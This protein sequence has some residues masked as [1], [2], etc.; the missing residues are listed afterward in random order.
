MSDADTTLR[1]HGQRLW[2]AAYQLSF[3]LEPPR[4]TEEVIADCLA[5]LDA[6]LEESAPH[7]DDEHPDFPKA[8]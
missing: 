5:V 2:D 3:A 1:L 4:A 8:P 7:F 6:M